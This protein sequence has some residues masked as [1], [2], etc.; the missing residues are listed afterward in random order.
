MRA[1]SFILLALSLSFYFVVKQ[2]QAA[3]RYHN[4]EGSDALPSAFWHPERKVFPTMSSKVN[5]PK[6]VWLLSYPNSG[7]SYTLTLVEKSS[8]FSIAT[9]Y[10]H[11]VTHKSMTSEPV[12]P[13]YTEGPFWEGL[14]GILKHTI[15]EL[16]DHY[17]LTKTHCGGRCLKC[18]ADEYVVDDVATFLQACA[19]TTIIQEGKRVESSYSPQS[20]VKKLVHLIRD[21]LHNV[22]AR[23][24]LDR[25]HQ[26]EK[27]ASV[28]EWLPYNATGFARWCEYFDTTYAESERRKF[29]KKFYKNYLLPVPCHAELYKY[30]Q[31]HNRAIE[32][33]DTLH[34][35]VLRIFY[36]DYHYNFNATATNIFNFLELPVRRPMREFRDLPNY[37]DHYT[38]L[39]RQ[40]ARKLAKHLASKETWQL[41]RH[42]FDKST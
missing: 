39:Q 36:E 5:P 7:T 25:R 27:N 17:V 2:I 19:R 40:A 11:E 42:Y 18:G 38:A 9:N 34:A 14:S 37:H 31:W 26:V 29:G 35:P 8:N 1:F 10:G 4:N 12:D 15:R 3:K 24:H 41:I 6:V 30:V 32:V 13:K 23:F 16:P 20:R 28:A 22:V 33:I 21:P